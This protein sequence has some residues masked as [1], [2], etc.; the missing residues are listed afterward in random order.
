MDTLNIDYMLGLLPVML[1]Y[2]PL[3]LKMACIGMVA[4]LVLA[5]LLAVVR[6]LKVP[7][8]NALTIVFISF[9]RGTPL[10]VQLFLFYYGLPQVMAFLTQID[11]VTVVIHGNRVDGRGPRDLQES[12]TGILASDLPSQNLVRPLTTNHGPSSGQELPRHWQGFQVDAVQGG[13][14]RFGPRKIGSNVLEL[15]LQSCDF[16][17][18][19]RNLRRLLDRAGLR[20][21]LGGASGQDH[22][23][24]SEHDSCTLNLQHRSIPS[25]PRTPGTPVSRA[26]RKSPRWPHW[27]DLRP[28]AVPGRN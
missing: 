10:L 4:A 20:T 22:G 21:H 7:V 8:L 25:G 11:G 1:K 9:F 12:R 13:I 28:R 27:P 14:D 26:A 19:T 5:S 16:A 23:R 2:L 24:A 3:T 18:K 15:D 6:V 17:L